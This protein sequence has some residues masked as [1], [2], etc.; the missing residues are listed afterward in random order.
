V[1]TYPGPLGWI[2]PLEGLAEEFVGPNSRLRRLMGS[3]RP[4]PRRLENKPSKRGPLRVDFGVG[5]QIEICQAIRIPQERP[6]NCASDL[7][8]PMGSFQIIQI[9]HLMTKFEDLAHNVQALIMAK[10][11]MEMKTYQSASLYDLASKR[12]TDLTGVWRGICRASG[13]PVCTIPEAATKPL[14]RCAD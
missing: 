13:Q 11:A 7:Q 6:S 9:R 12:H 4:T 5:R 10:L 2:Y 3:D 8:E 1:W 14:N